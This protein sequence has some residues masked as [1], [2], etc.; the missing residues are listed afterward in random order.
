MYMQLDIFDVNPRDVQTD[1][2]LPVGQM[3]VDRRNPLSG[4]G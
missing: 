3:Y 4:D 1:K 2:K